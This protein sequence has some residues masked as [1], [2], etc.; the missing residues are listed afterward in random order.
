MNSPL[1]DLRLMAVSLRAESVLE[2]DLRDPAGRVLAPFTAG[3]HI[4][5]HLDAGMIRSYSLCNDPRET[6]RYVVAVGKDAASRGGSRYLHEAIRVGATVKAS[7]PRN[8]FELDEDAERSVLV[9]GGIGVTP[10][11][12][13]AQRL[14]AIGRP[15]D[16]LYGARSRINA[17]YLPELEALAASSGN[18]LTLHFDDEAGGPANLAAALSAM[19][20]HAHAYCCGPAPMIEAFRAEAA[21]RLPEPQIHIEFFKAAAPPDISGGAFTVAL[22]RSGKRFDVPAGKSMLDVLLDAGIDVPYSCMEGICGSCQVDVLAGTPDHRDSVLSERQKS[23][24]KVVI[25]C[26]SRSKTE[27][28]LLDL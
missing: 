19:P 11:W 2:F 12:C 8:T 23:A 20:R 3:S 4:D 24:N 10:L 15:W 14:T 13:M 25:A 5:L 28:L 9:A 6:H 22:K 18:K 26:C 16:M 27:T 7:A 17:A 21:K 1:L